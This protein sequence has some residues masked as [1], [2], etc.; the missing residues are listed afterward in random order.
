[1]LLLLLRRG[2]SLGRQGLRLPRQQVRRRVQCY[3]TL[4]V[5]GAMSHWLAAVVG[6]WWVSEQTTRSH[7]SAITHCREGGRPPVLLL[8]PD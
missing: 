3:V 6:K 8:G 1:M 2:A 7:R 5:S 4:L